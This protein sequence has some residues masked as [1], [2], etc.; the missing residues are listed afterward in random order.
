MDHHRPSTGPDLPWQAWRRLCPGKLAG[1]PDL[2]G[3]PRLPPARATRHLW[4]HH[5]RRLSVAGGSHHGSRSSPGSSPGSTQ[6]QYAS[7]VLLWKVMLQELQVFTW[8]TCDDWEGHAKK[9]NHDMN[10]WGFASLSYSHVKSRIAKSGMTIAQQA[11]WC[12]AA[13]WHPG[14]PLQ[15]GGLVLSGAAECWRWSAHSHV[16]LLRKKFEGKFRYNKYQQIS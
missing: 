7:T 12:L 15:L 13:I 10:W 14:L 1:S 8:T 4:G 11:S 2:P 3:S 9:D 16:H 5:G 6:L